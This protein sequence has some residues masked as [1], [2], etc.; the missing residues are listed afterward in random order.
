[1]SAEFPVSCQV[2]IAK[3]Q[4]RFC[5][6]CL[7]DLTRVLKVRRK[8]G[9]GFADPVLGGRQIFPH[10]GSKE[11]QQVLL[12]GRRGDIGN[13]AVRQRVPDRRA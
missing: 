10:F 8:I 13:G 11:L 1:M 3:L 5:G 4:N 12:V 2:P 9:V 7:D 6:T